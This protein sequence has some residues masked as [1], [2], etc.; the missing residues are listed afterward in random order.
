MLRSECLQ[1]HSGCAWGW[2]AASSAAMC[3]RTCE[4]TYHQST[5]TPALCAHMLFTQTAAAAFVVLHVLATA[6]G[7]AHFLVLNQFT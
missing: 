2:P 1:V 4:C 3:W 5:R 6:R 7:I